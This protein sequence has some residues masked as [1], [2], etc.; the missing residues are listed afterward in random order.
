MND[1]LIERLARANPVPG[2]MASLNID[3]VDRRLRD[4]P[5]PRRSGRSARGVKH[6][7]GRLMIVVPLAVTCVVVAV[8]VLLVGNRHDPVHR[9]SPAVAVRTRHP[10]QPGFCRYQQP[11]AACV[12]TDHGRF[13]VNIQ[14]PLLA[15]TQRDGG[16]LPATVTRAL[17]RIGRL[18][19]GPHAYVLMVAGTRVIP[20]T[21]IAGVTSLTTGQVT[22]TLDIHQGPAALRRTLRVWI[23]EALSHQVDAS[24]RIETGP[25]F[26]TTLLQQMIS[27]GVASAFDI[28]L[29]PTIHLPWTTALTAHQEHVMWSRARPLL[30]HTGLLDQW[31]FGGGGVPE[32][33]AFEIGYDIVRDYLDRHPGATAAS[34]VDMPAMAIFSHSHYSP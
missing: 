4:E 10:A 23:P 15:V 31:F 13:T 16:N 7:V 33:T 30:N 21:G 22:I 19:P 14:T 25:G 26:G 27:E 29:Q 8:A 17:D 28:Q 24:V 9:Q 12:V 2:R 3:E 34:L 20:H 11:V 5:T 18:L 32:S 1:E 6:V